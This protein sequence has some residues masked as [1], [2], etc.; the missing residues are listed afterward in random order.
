MGELAEY[1][2]LVREAELEVSAL[3]RQC[4]G[5]EE[6]LDTT[7]E[8][9]LLAQEKFAEASEARED[10]D[11]GRKV[12]ESR[13]ALDAERIKKL[14]QQLQEAQMIAEDSDKNYD[15]V[16]QKLSALE[17]EAERADDRL[18]DDQARTMELTEEYKVVADNMKSFEASEAV[19]LAKE[20][21]FEEIIRDLTQRLKDAET[22][23]VKER[24]KCPS[25]PRT[26]RPL[27]R[28]WPPGWTSTLQSIG[29]LRL[30]TTRCPDISPG[31]KQTS[32]LAKDS[33]NAEKE[34]AT[35]MDKHAA[36][37]RELETTYNEMS[38]Y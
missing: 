38:G 28:N 23:P 16:S 7:E 3:Q 25:L 18:S 17:V 9:I 22:R 20:E 24:N 29:S 19:A 12:L 36:I 31:E 30:L 14:E 5:K 2:K 33:E 27:R 4:S 11:R 35:W 6:S 37:Y 21:S 26:L 1:E 34:L 8:R 32:Q 10:S 13:C 15:Q